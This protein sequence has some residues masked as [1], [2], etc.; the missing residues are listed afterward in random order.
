M[1]NG[2]VAEVTYL[3]CA[4]YFS[5]L[6]DRQKKL[7]LVIACISPNYMLSVVWLKLDENCGVSDI[8]V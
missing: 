2:N 8:K 6:S 7:I 1:V 3:Q 5:I 4:I